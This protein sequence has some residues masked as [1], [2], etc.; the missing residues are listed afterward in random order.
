MKALEN[1]FLTFLNGKKQFI[2]PIYQR[3]YSWTR[4]QCEQLWN[5]IV[6]IATD[7]HTATHFVG[8]I[9]YIQHGPAIAGGVM[10]LLVI[11]G[12]QRLTTLSLLLIALAKAAKDSSTPLRM[13]QEDIYDSYLI[14]KHGKGEEYYKLLL[15]Q[16]DKDT[17]I[18]LTDD[19]DH[20]KATLPTHRLLENYVYFE[21]R[22][23]QGDVD[24]FALYTGI[25]R[26]M[27][28]EISLDKDHDHPQLIFESLNSTGMAL[29]QADLIRNYILMGL[30][31]KEQIKLYKKYWYPMEENFLHRGDS[32][33]FDRFMRDYLTIKQGSIP[34]IGQVY[35]TFKTYYSSIAATP[36]GEIMADIERYAMHYVKMAFLKEEHREIRRVLDDIN[37]LKVD[38]AY[39]FLLRV[40][41]DYTRKLLSREDFIAILKL[42]ES[43]MFRRAICGIPTNSTNKTFAALAKE[44]DEEHYLTSIEAAFLRKDSHQRFPR[45]EEFHAAFLVK[46]VY[47]FRSRNYLLR[48]LE[49][50]DTKEPA[51]IEK[52]TIEHIMPQNEHLS[53]AWQR[54]LGPN[55]KE[56][57]ARYLHTIGNLTLTA[58]NPELSD[59]PFQEKRDDMEGGFRQSHIHLNHSLAQVEHWNE[60]AIKKRAAALADLAVKLWAAPRYVKLVTDTGSNSYSLQDHLWHM[61]FDMRGIFERLRKRILNLDSSVREQVRKS[62]IVYSATDDFLEIELQK[63]KLLLTLNI[64]FGEINGP[65][66]LFKNGKHPGHFDSGKVQLSVTSLAQVEDVMDLIRQVFEKHMEE[67]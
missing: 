17:M 22:T 26:L 6:R 10:P 14:N 42:V 21:N 53:F 32:S 66:G 31:N 19:P 48:K 64:N 54:E 38:V 29:S 9:V 67:G 63:K 12:Q 45:D 11:D 1:E 44:I 65:K 25:S 3:T 57:H 55:W 35:A 33:H 46:D 59:R 60:E 50:S 5:D 37:T 47:N 13:S 51:T 24:P 20:A 61:P 23:H 30:D 39:P 41:E 7:K 36:I 62:Y 27:I 16:S 58:Y 56:I 34:N 52:Y 40:Y 15:T 49:N 18:A 43:Y 2:I 8:S 28:V 4:E